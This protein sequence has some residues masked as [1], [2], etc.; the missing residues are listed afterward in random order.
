MLLPILAAATTFVLASHAI[1]HEGATLPAT[2]VY[3]GYNCTGANMS[4]DLEW[5]GARK[6]TKSFALTMFDPDAPVN[7]GWWHW[8][9]FNIPAGWSGLKEN[10]GAASGKL[11]AGAMI[12]GMTSF[13]S[14]AYGGPCPPPGPA[15]HYVFTLY[16][17]DVAKVDGAGASTTGPD[18]LKLI[19]KHTLA[20]TTLT[21]RYGR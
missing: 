21:G 20:K 11:T 19:E 12:Q 18:L 16:A 3:H 4:P 2:S 15:H 10:A 13:G 6:A 14:P 8:I 5:S 1:P 9:V 7:G 17:L